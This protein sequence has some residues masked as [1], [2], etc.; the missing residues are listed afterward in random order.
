MASEYLWKY[1]STHPVW[2]V[3]LDG[4]RRP[5]VYPEEHLL[6]VHDQMFPELAAGGVWQRRR[7]EIV[8]RKWWS[9]A[10]CSRSV[11]VLCC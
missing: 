2:Y 4:G 10:A 1:E 7:C 6:N 9:G 11:F 5:E 8:L 3:C